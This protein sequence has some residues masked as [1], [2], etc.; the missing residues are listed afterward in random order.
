MIPLRPYTKKSPLQPTEPGAP[1]T[2]CKSETR[3][4]NRASDLL[5]TN[6]SMGYN[7]NLYLLKICGGDLGKWQECPTAKAK[8]LTV[9]GSVTVYGE[10]VYFFLADDDL[11]QRE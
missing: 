4:R 7:R 3:I 9:L 2:V 5:K 6:E 8:A 1:N 10:A 11:Q